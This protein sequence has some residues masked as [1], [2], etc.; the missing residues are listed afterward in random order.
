MNRNSPIVLA[1][2]RFIKWSLATLGNTFFGIGGIFL[3]IIIALYVAGALIQPARWYLV[4][5]A[6]ALLLLCGGLLALFYA[7]SVLNR[8]VSAQRMQVSDTNKKL[9]YINKKL[10]ETRKQVADISKKVSGLTKDASLIKDDVSLIGYDILKEQSK[11]AE[12]VSQL[13][14]QTS[15]DKM[16]DQ[17]LNDSVE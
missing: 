7:R 11:L 17:S 9:W 3:F 1:I 14:S 6:S 8:F 13:E 2:S 4:G 15:N 12:R 16:A 10:S 5:V